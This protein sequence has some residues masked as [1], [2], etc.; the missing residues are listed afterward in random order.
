MSCDCEAY[1]N[2]SDGNV[3]VPV[4]DESAE[5]SH[6]CEHIMESD[7][8]LEFYQKTSRSFSVRYGWDRSIG[9]DYV[10]SGCSDSYYS[11]DNTAIAISTSVCSEN[12]I[13]ET[14]VPYY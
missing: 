14:N 8:V 1:V 4:I 5:Y 13:R 3:E 9:I 6:S 11:C 2:C 10:L 12:C 7:D